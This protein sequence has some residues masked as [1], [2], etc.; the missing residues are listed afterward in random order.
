MTFRVLAV[1]LC[2]RGLLLAACPVPLGS[3]VYGSYRVSTQTQLDCLATVVRVDGDLYLNAEHFTEINLPNLQYVTG[4]LSIQDDTVAPTGTCNVYLSGLRDTFS[5]SVSSKVARVVRFG[6]LADTRSISIDSPV[7]TTFEMPE[8]TGDDLYVSAPALTSLWVSDGTPRV[9]TVNLAK[10]GL[11]SL[12]DTL[13]SVEEARS[14][15]LTDNPRLEDVSFASLKQ[16]GSLEITGSAVK[17]L[18]AP[19]GLA[20]DDQLTLNGVRLA[21]LDGLAGARSLNKVVIASV[22]LL[23]R[24]FTWSQATSMTLLDIRDAPSLADVSGLDA[25]QTIG[26]LTLLRNAKLKTLKLRGL[27]TLHREQIQENP[28]LPTCAVDALERQ[29]YQP[30]VTRIVTDTDPTATCP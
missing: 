5:V 6:N 26:T 23:T 20:V 17:T 19:E 14:I 28:L 12:D 3:V 15:I 4:F 25:V 13:G 7:L 11:S 16:V 27:K 8:F 2:L 24:L 10:T 1:L 21:N 18:S 22:P 9:G 30:P 29:L